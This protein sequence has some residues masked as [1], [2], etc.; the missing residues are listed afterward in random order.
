MKKLHE[1]MVNIQVENS[2]LQSQSSSLL[3]QINQ[4]QISQGSLETFKRKA[5]ASK[6]AF[7]LLPPEGV[8]SFTPKNLCAKGA[9]AVVRKRGEMATATTKEKEKSFQSP[10]RAAEKFP[11]A[12]RPSAAFVRD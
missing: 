8:S 5:S 10:L 7:L 11:L 3:S 6:W 1:E 4:L 12:V 9:V 2:T